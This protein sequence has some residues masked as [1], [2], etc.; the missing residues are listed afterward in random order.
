MAYKLCEDSEYCSLIG[1]A[2]G[3]A[4]FERMPISLEFDRP[5]IKKLLGLPVVLEDIRQFD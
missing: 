1:Y 3:K 4:L 2:L 5:F